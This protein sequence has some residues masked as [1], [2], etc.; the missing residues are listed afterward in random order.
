M[1]YWINT[2]ISSNKLINVTDC[3]HMSLQDALDEVETYNHR[4]CVYLHTIHFN[5][6]ISIMINMLPLIA[7]NAENAKLDCNHEEQE[8]IIVRSQQIGGM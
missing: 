2:Y 8:S 7:E 3:P 1:E 4:K 6:G 5:N